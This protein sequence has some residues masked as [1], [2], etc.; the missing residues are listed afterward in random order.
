MKKLLYI[1]FIFAFILAFTSCEKEVIKPCPTMDETSDTRMSDKGNEAGTDIPYQT[2]GGD[3]L[4]G[5][6]DEVVDPDEDEDFDEDDDKI[7][8]PDEDEDFE[9]KEGENI[10]DPDKDEDFEEEEPEGK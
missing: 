7:V 9:K 2:R 1:S 4:E 8:D 5:G 10:V 6:G 3:G